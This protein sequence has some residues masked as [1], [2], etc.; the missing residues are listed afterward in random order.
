[1]SR[2]TIG[3][4]PFHV[5]H[6]STLTMKRFLKAILSCA[7]AG[8]LLWSP[9]L[10]GQGYKV[11]DLG[12]QIDP[13]SYALAINQ[14]GQVAGYGRTEAGA[15]AFLYSAGVVTQLGPLGDTNSYGTSL[16]LFGYMAGFSDLTYGARAFIYH[17]GIVQRLE[18]L[19]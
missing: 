10:A 2:R 6:E 11:V 9:F 5:R 18:Q 4:S 7:G 3:C 1:M 17:D 13:H 15:R 19:A 8:T 12:A 16:N 14:R